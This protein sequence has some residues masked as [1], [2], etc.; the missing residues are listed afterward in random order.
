MLYTNKILDKKT[1][2]YPI[3]W[4]CRNV[5]TISRVKWLMVQIF[6]GN[7]FPF[8]RD[9]ILSFLNLSSLASLG[10]V[11][12]MLQR[13]VLDYL[14]RKV[15]DRSNIQNKY[16]MLQLNFGFPHPFGN[17]WPLK[18]GLKYFG[19]IF[20]HQ[21][22]WRRLSHSSAR[23]NCCTNQSVHV[24]PSGSYVATLCQEC[25]LVRIY[26]G[27]TLVMSSHLIM[28]YD[29]NGMCGIVASEELFFAYC[30]ASGMIFD[31]RLKYNGPVCVTKGN[32]ISLVANN[33]HAVI[34]NTV[35]PTL[36][37]MDRVHACQF[38][39]RVSLMIN[40]HCAAVILF[41]ENILIVREKRPYSQ[42]G[43]LISEVR[44]LKIDLNTCEQILFIDPVSSQR[45]LPLPDNSGFLNI[46]KNTLGRLVLQKYGF[47]PLRSRESIRRFVF[48]DRFSLCL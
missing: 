41:H 21:T 45:S 11:H 19:P 23:R 24:T 2:T 43:R 6:L 39:I 9:Q 8:I 13:K 16:L 35:S 7:G 1:K 27:E 33:T 14:T 12:P 5:G 20:R 34:A 4:W 10:M 47:L 46:E 30:G 42:N 37:V 32:E 36:I 18:K 25:H 26:H 40:I 28:K 38:I 15:T 22:S 48:E 3:W 31:P 29:S 17:A 44:Y